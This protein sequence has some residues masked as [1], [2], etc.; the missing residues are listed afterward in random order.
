VKLPGLSLPQWVLLGLI[1]GILTGIFFGD[2]CSVLA[3]LSD[4]FVKIWQITVLPSVAISLIVG[5]GSLKKNDAKNVV[6]KAGLVLVMFWI[7]GTAV[8]FSLQL[9]F[10]A[11]ENAFFFS[12]QSLAQ[13]DNLSIVDMFV[14]SNPFRSLSEG[15]L[16][17]IVIF[18]LFLGFG[19][20]VDK[21]SNQILRPLNIFQSALIRVTCILSMTYPIGV[22]IIAAETT[23]SITLEGFLELQVFLISLAVSAALLSLVVLP[24]LVTCLTTFRYRDIISAS[25]SAMILGFSTGS[26]FIILPLIMEGVKNLFEGGF[27]KRAMNVS[28]E[29]HDD[30]IEKHSEDPNG[31]DL[32]KFERSSGD[33]PTQY[34]NQVRYYSGILVPLG[35]TFPLLGAFVPFLFILFVAWLYNSP[36]DLLEQIKLIAVGI[37]N[38]FGSSKVSVISLLNLMHLPSDAYNLYISTG[39]MRQCFVAPLTCMSI[40]SF[41]TISIVL[42]ENKYRLRWSRAIFFI[43]LALL[44]AAL[45]LGGLKMGFAYLLAND[46]HGSDLFSGIELPLDSDGKKWNEVVNTTVYLRPQDVPISTPQGLNQADEIKEI[47]KRGVLRVGYNSNNIPFVFFNSQGE[48]VG[49]DVQMAY[50]LAKFIN[51]SRIEFVPVLG[52]TLSESLNHGY[53]DIIMSSIIVTSERLGE[54]KYTD[55]YISVHMAFMVPDERKKE[56][57]KLDNVRRMSNLRIAVLNQSAFMGVAGQLFPQAKIVP[58]ES[59]KDFFAGGR[60]DALFITSEE[61][62]VMTRMHPFFDVAVFEPNDYFPIFYAYPVAKNSTDTFLMLLN[63]WL[64]MEKDYGGLDE[65]YNYWILG[66]SAGESEPRWSVMRNVLNWTT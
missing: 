50:E 66:S 31:D 23:G 41:T 25:S 24:L 53:C 33:D 34:Y 55:P 17:A 12:T 8:F 14:P 49:Y 63:Y 18:C 39:L 5:V 40:F 60:A 21:N 36:L 20:M 27:E 7:I 29:S 47:K 30:L 48:L 6:V 59:Y 3:P 9:A 28:T 54:M 51:V 52:D 2:Y 65:K 1:L 37:P 42:L 61:G 4:A 58:I 13:T 15:L 56:F 26:E 62:Y 64:K 44:F 19:L 43:I 38:L 10:P 57:L 16:P 22:F 35:Y 11:I 32:E 45:M 46:H